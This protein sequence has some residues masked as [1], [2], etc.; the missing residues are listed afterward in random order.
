MKIMLRMVGLMAAMAFLA[1]LPTK[2][3]SQAIILNDG[4]TGAALN[5]NLWTV[6]TPYCDSG[7]NASNVGAVFINGGQLLSK[8]TLPNQIIIQGSFA[9]TGNQYDQFSVWL[10]TDGTKLNGLNQTFHT[11]IQFDFS[12]S[13]DP[14]SGNPAGVSNVGIADNAS[15]VSV[16]T[17]FALALNTFY[18]FQIVD[19]GSNV[20]LYLSNLNT[21]LLT[22]D[23]TNRAG[24]LIGLQNRMGACGGSSISAGSVSQLQFVTVYSTELAAYTAVELDFIALAG[25]TYQIQG[26]TDFVNWASVGPPIVGS[27]QNVQRL[28]STRGTNAQYYRLQPP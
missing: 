19:S 2:V 4:F 8:S 23:T 10:R 21:P 11:G 18:P 3:F 22:M 26:S 5:T 9:I 20:T 6:I 27:N 15:N 7:M 13:Q 17:N 28:F 12:Y 24:N 1:A 14:A 16:S 25:K